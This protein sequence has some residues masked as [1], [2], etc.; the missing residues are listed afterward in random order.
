MLAHLEDSA[1]CVATSSAG[2]WQPIRAFDEQREGNVRGAPV[3][4]ICCIHD[5]RQCILPA[6]CLEPDISQSG[7][8]MH[9]ASP[10]Q[11]QPAENAYGEKENGG[12]ANAAAPARA[13]A[14][15][16]VEDGAAAL[17]GADISVRPCTDS[18]ADVQWCRGWQLLQPFVCVHTA[19]GLMQMTSIAPTPQEAEEEKLLAPES[20]AEEE[21]RLRQHRKQETER[22]LQVAPLSLQ[23]VA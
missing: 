2:N 19:T 7:L 3:L 4:N 5:A 22:A 20:A 14:G 18:A 16:A 21:E 13:S 23:R 15:K 10:A 12:A 6:R 17:L 9:R 11:P 1:F 8:R